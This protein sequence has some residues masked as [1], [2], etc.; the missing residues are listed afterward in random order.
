M[1]LCN[2]LPVNSL[3]WSFFSTQMLHDLTKKGAAPT[4]DD[5]D[6]DVREHEMPHSLT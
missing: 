1:Y 6:F 5:L 2:V 4:M 3:F